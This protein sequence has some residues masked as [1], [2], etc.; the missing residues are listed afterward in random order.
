MD[1]PQF[2]R[3]QKFKEKKSQIWCVKNAILAVRSP[4]R[5]WKKSSTIRTEAQS[6]PGLA[7]LWTQ[8]G[9]SD[10]YNM[11]EAKQSISGAQR[12]FPAQRATAKQQWDLLFLLWGTMSSL[13]EQTDYC[14]FSIEFPK[15]SG[16]TWQ[17]PAG[18]DKTWHPHLAC[19]LLTTV[20][21]SV[22]ISVCRLNYSFKC[23]PTF[24]L[25]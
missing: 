21:I 6:S 17:V 16:G 20:F 24:I 13:K 2:Q 25:I 15:E 19:L 8:T 18:T 23:V 3:N 12:G 1:F 14:C 22:F 7:L 9:S 10:L 11:L 5:L 4:D